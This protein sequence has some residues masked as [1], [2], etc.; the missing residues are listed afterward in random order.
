MKT[1]VVREFETHNLQGVP[2][3]DLKE[4]YVLDLNTTPVAD[5]I[6]CWTCWWKTPGRCIYKDLN[7]FYHHYVNADRAVFAAQVTRGFVSG[8]LKTLFD[9]MIPLYLPYTDFSSGESMHVPRYE[10][11]PKVEFYY[12]GKFDSADGRNI[13]EDYIKRVFYQFYT[14]LV[15]VKPL[16]GSIKVSTEKGGA[17]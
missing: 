5:C 17:E 14:E 8:K 3:V 6:G 9:R 16:D 4:A 10:H 2:D 7:E 13:F 1:V 12:Q 15:S 11:Y